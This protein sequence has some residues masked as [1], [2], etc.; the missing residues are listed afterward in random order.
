MGRGAAQVP[1]DKRVGPLIIDETS[2]RPYAAGAFSQEWRVVARAAG[3]PDD[4]WNVD[5]RAGAIAEAEDA[6]ADLD[7]VRSA[8]AHAQAATKARYSRGAVKKS[9]MVAKLRLAH[10]SVKNWHGT[11]LGKA[12]SAA[13]CQK[14]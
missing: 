6:G 13:D 1:A 12:R 8:A 2:G 5:A 4:I 10:R 14:G 9:R 11:A 7:H 3:I